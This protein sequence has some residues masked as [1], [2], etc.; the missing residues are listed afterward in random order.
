MTV[1][2]I[3]PHPAYRMLRRPLP[4]RVYTSAN[5]RPPG[6]AQRPMHFSWF[7]DDDVR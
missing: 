1:T 4:S 5:R 6:F 3:A 7:V 2:K